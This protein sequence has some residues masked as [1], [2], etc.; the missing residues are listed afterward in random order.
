MIDFI[1][2][3]NFI[4]VS[5]ILIV[6]LFIIKYNTNKNKFFIISISVSIIYMLFINFV[7]EIRGIDINQFPKMLR[8]I[9]YFLN[10]IFSINIIG[11]LIYTIFKFI[12]EKT[13]KNKL[14][15]YCISIGIVSMPLIIIYPIATRCF[16]IC[17]VFLIIICMNLLS[18]AIK[19]KI[20]NI[21]GLSIIPIILVTIIL[22]NK[23]YIFNIINY[24]F[25]EI[26][27]YTE[28]QMVNKNINTIVVPD[29]KYKEYIHIDITSFIGFLY[30]H[31]T[32]ND[33]KFKTIDRDKW[34]EIANNK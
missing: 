11:T 15:F 3:D 14:Y 28:E 32:P 2:I 8:I 16:F 10:C 30:Y 18:Y 5:L 20:I 13:L 25:K 29:F 19:Y 4:L 23:Y 1:I 26:I 33:I 34:E 21:N 31:N 27:S 9:K 6:C 17:Y 7:F 24:Q 12:E 22:I